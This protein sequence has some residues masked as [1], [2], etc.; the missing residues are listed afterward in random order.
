MTLYLRLSPARRSSPTEERAEAK[1]FGGAL[2]GEANGV[3]TGSDIHDAAKA[4]EGD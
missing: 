4:T 1:N 3:L 2:A